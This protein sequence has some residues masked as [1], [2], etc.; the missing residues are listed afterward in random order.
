MKYD[1][2]IIGSGLGG[3]TAGAKLSREGKKVL[4]IEQHDRPGGYATTFR[5]GDFTFEVGL[6][7][8]DGPAAGDIKTRI[9]NDLDVFKSVEFLQVPE[10]YRF[11]NGRIDMVI[12]HDPVIAAERLSGLFPEEE[13]GI[14]AFFDRITKPVRK[15][16]SGVGPDISIGEFLD[17][18][19]KNE[20]LK[21]VLLGNLGYFHDDPYSL[22]LSYYSA[23]QGSYFAGGAS[24]IRGGS[25]HLSD[26]L[27]GFISDHGG[28]VLLNRT[29]TGIMTENS[30]VTG[31][32]FRRKN[33]TSSINEAFADEVIANNAMPNVAGLLPENYGNALTNELKAQKT[34]AS[35]LTIY[36]GFNKPLRD[37]GYNYYSASVFDKS[38]VSQ[39]DIAG[40]NSGDYRSRSFIFADYSQV[41]SRLAPAGK[42]V[43]AICCIDYLKDWEDLERKEYAAKKER[44]AAIFIKKLEELIPGAGG[45]IE[46][47]E[48]GTPSTLRRYT[49]NPGGAVYGFAQLPSR[50]TIDTSILPDNLHFASAWGKTGGGFSGAIYSGYFCA[51]NILRKTQVHRG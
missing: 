6:H 20:D 24:F 4:L 26:H 34:G 47:Y 9:F 12:P 40:N 30:K 51:V 35:L 39:R 44:V 11:V 13:K 25:Q 18:I 17:T 31:V 46:S 19:I 14:K 1:V 5:R 2:I 15:P 21:L 3:L 41:D 10:F 8:M 42:G 16:L 7:E 28:E 43:G 36:L 23:A 27:S 22:S 45:I 33:D 50:Q 49:L 37:L 32:T 38:I 29:V 48:V